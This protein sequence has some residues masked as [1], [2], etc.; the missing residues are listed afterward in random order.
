MTFFFE[1]W[2]NCSF[3]KQYAKKIFFFLPSWGSLTK[4]LAGS[5]SG[6]VPKCHYP[7]RCPNLMMATLCR[8]SLVCREL[9]PP[10]PQSAGVRRLAAAAGA[11]RRARTARPGGRREPGATRPD[12]QGGGIRPLTWRP[13]LRK[14]RWRCLPWSS[15]RPWKKKLDII[16]TSN[17]RMVVVRLVCKYLHNVEVF[18]TLL[19]K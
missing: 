6:S 4:I 17:F 7:N 14:H 13:L 12:E 9:R 10:A 19:K 16:Y 18:C 1:K 5:G 15:P 3:K 2:C 8:P 11:K